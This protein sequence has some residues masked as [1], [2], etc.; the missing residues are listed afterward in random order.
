MNTKNHVIGAEVFFLHN[1]VVKKS[2]VAGWVKSEQLKHKK[3]FQKN[4]LLET[5]V[6]DDV[7]VF[8]DGEDDGLVLRKESCYSTKEELIANL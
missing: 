1:N 7:I 3:F 6:V 5:N 2:F 8:F 4:R